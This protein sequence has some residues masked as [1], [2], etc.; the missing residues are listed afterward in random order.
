MNC[1]ISAAI[2][3]CVSSCEALGLIDTRHP[4][5]LDQCSRG[6]DE[7]AEVVAGRKAVG[8]G[9]L[10]AHK[11]FADTERAVDLGVHDRWV[12]S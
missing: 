6:L 12:D 9:I 10:A 4:H 5:V 8:S 3:S 7:G 11:D 2:G 1:L